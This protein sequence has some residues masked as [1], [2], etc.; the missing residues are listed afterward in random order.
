[1][2][3]ADG[4]AKVGDFGAAYRYVGVGAS[5]LVER[6]EVRAFGCLVEELAARTST[7]PGAGRVAELQALAEECMGDEVHARPSFAELAGRAVL[8][9]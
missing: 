4:T 2:V 9:M 3:A 8:C 6:V 5:E 7:D 1:M